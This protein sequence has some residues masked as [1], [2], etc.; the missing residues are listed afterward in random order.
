MSEKPRIRSHR[1]LIVWQKA[2]DLVESVYRES[3]SFPKTELYGLTSQVRR[4]AVSIPANIAEGQGRRLVGEYIHFPGNAR[5]SL[6]EVDTHLEI[7]S[8]LGF[9]N[10]DN[11]LALAVQ[12]TEVRKLLNGLMRSL[13]N[14]C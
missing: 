5:G 4:A 8:R 14:N 3:D 6:L 9:M 2:M 11:H 7:A 13:D 10:P 12:L 1:D